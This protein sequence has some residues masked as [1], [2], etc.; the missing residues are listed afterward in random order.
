MLSQDMLQEEGSALA[1]H[2]CIGMRSLSLV[3][4]CCWSQAEMKV[5]IGKERV[6]CK[7]MNLSI[8]IITMVIISDMAKIKYAT[9]LRDLYIHCSWIAICQAY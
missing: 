9:C 5:R 8:L 1:P 3:S 2:C 6:T 7:I 4:L